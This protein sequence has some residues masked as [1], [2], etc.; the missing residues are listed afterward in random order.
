MRLSPSYAENHD[1]RPTYEIGRA[2][3]SGERQV[4]MPFNQVQRDDTRRCIRL[5]A[6]DPLPLSEV[7]GELDRIAAEGLWQ[8]GLLVDLRRGILDPSDRTRLQQ[9]IAAIDARHGPHGPMALVTIRPRDIGNAQVY[10]IQSR[11][12]MIQVFWDVEE[13]NAWLDSHLSNTGSSP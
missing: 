9:H 10:V 8:Y 12:E 7:V 6:T 5:S 1:G 13:A 4:Q 2:S 3:R 11:T